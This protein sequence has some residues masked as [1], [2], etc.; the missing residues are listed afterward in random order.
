MPSLPMPTENTETQYSIDKELYDGAIAIRDEMN[1]YSERLNKMDEHKGEVSEAVYLRVKSDYLAK[2]DLVKKS[3]EEKKQE[4]QKALL[5]LY[6]KKR[7]QEAE[8]QKHKDVLEEAKFRNFLGE[9][10]DKK[11]KETDTRE[12]AEVKRLEKI[13]ATIQSNTKQYEDLVGGPVPEHEPPP[14]PPEPKPALKETPAAAPQVARL[15]TAKEAPTTTKPVNEGSAKAPPPEPEA[16]EESIDYLLEE[17]EDEPDYFQS[18][19]A[20]S[21]PAPAKE[22]SPSSL[23]ETGKFKIPSSVPTEKHAAEKRS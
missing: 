2:L 13:L 3:F 23:A 11:F 10:T 21:K 5:S 6:D 19:P 20:P 15:A 17:E 1:L 16:E 12:S 18:E 7:E 22:P 8:L 4:I 9:I 14:P